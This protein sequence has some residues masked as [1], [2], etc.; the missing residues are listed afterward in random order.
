MPPFTVA[1]S[2]MAGSFL[3][4]RYFADDYDFRRKVVLITGGSRGLGLCMAREL[5]K[6]RARIAIVARHDEEVKNAVHDLASRGAEVLG[7][8]ADIRDPAQVRHVVHRVE[9]TLGPVDVLINNAG[10]ISVGPIDH[11]SH[12]DFEEALAVH[13]WAPLYMMETVIPSMRMRRGGR[14]VNIASIGGKIGVPHLAPYCASKFALVGLSQSLRAELA[15]DNIT[16]T[17][18]NPGLM[19]TGSHMNARFKGRHTE[20]FT[21][22]ALFDALPLASMNAQRAARKIVAACRRG[23]AQLTL[24]IPAKLA[25]ALH[26][27]LPNLMAASMARM[28]R[29]LPGVSMLHDTESFSGWESQSKWAPSTLT[30]LADKAT[31]QNNE[32]LARNADL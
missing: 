31:V 28:N 9:E 32:C 15:E 5:A 6:E 20:E 22:F 3:A 19:R 14:I 11:M 16:V 1:A 25:V 24:S 2:L 13:F 26:N 10:V 4:S 30:R 18:I 8:P 29:M 17:L 7:I 12:R 27:T 21:W 23:D